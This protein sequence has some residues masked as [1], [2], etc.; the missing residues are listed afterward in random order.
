MKKILIPAFVLS[1]LSI[2]SVFAENEMACI[3]MTQSAVD[4]SGE[5]E[6]FATSCEVPNGWR[7]VY[8]CDDIKDVN[9]G[10]TPEQST[11]R[12]YKLKMKAISKKNEN[13]KTLKDK[14]SAKYRRIGGGSFTRSTKNT[15]LL[16]KKSTKISD[17]KFTIPNYDNLRS[18]NLYKKNAPK[19][20]Y[21]TK[22]EK[23]SD[24]EEKVD[25]N[26]ETRTYRPGI[27]SSVSDVFREGQLSNAQKWSKQQE[28]RVRGVI[29]GK[30]PYSLKSK[31]K[32]TPKRRV[33]E[34]P[35]LKRTYKGDLLQGDLEGRSL[36]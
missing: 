19:R 21:N 27:K 8:S 17:R 11:E 20:K 34:G 35:K 29:T 18:Y 1:I 9:F 7:M 16:N 24:L 2:S 36:R 3:K 4:S 30:N 15:S 25:N 28:G 13:R 10:L 22:R 14:V 31:I 33:Y 12:R 26:E 6:E 32:R 5:C 23:I